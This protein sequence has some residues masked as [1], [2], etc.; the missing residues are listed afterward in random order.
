MDANATR[1]SKLPDA[2]FNT[3]DRELN[4]SGASGALLV[5]CLC[6]LTLPVSQS[7]VDEVCNVNVKDVLGAGD[8]TGL[9]AQARPL[10]RTHERAL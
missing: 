8:T 7:L 6:S 1:I 10:A 2:C 5:L 3:K 4:I 9:R